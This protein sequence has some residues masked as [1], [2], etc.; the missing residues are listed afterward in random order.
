MT[1]SEQNPNQPTLRRPEIE[2]AWRRATMSGLDP[3]ME[4]RE[5]AISDVE[6]RSTLSIAAGPV[7]DKMVDELADTRFSILLADRTS[8]IVDRRVTSSAIGRAL[9]R[10]LAVPGFQYLEEV[11]GT[12]SLATAFELRRPIAVTGEEHFLEALRCFCCYGV[13]IIHPVTHRLEGVI[14][15]SGPV[16]DATT[17]L[18]PF[19]M[20]AAR[21]IEERLLEGS[22]VAEKQLLAE[23]QAHANQ[24]R[25]AVVA[26][27]ENLVLTNTAAVDLVKGSDHVAL[28]AIA[29]DLPGT[30]PVE[31]S[32]TLSSGTEVSVRARAVSGSHGG[33][34]FEI[35]QEDI[36]RTRRT[37]GPSTAPVISTQDNAPP[38]N[39]LS[40][41]ILI[42][43]EP[44]T[45]RTTTART[46]AGA[47]CTVSDAADAIEDERQWFLDVR[48]ALREDGTPVVIDN[49]HALSPWLA[50]QLT[51]PVRVSRNQVV[52]TSAPLT[53]LGTAHRALASLALTRHELQPLRSYP[54]KL[55]S[56]AKSV[57]AEIL[58]DSAVELA[59][60]ALQLLA[61]QPWPGNI[62]ELRAVLQYAARGRERGMIIESDLPETVRMNTQS[63]RTLTL[64][65][66]AE[67]DAI[68]AALR[69]SHGNRA[70]AAAELGIGRTTL[71]DRLRRYGI[72]DA[73]PRTSVRNRNSSTVRDRRM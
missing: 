25:H 54:H 50:D 53:E 59:P 11:S 30:A 24:R 56:V 73:E 70:A 18:G 29:A 23:F 40:R 62:R 38:R 31:R 72:T 22:R 1:T 4:V 48:S 58:P 68:V 14:D 20:R 13:P 52:L 47:D 61:A 69:A 8:R 33:A 10:V 12:N 19:L 71:Y 16:A 64:M 7:L 15:V 17:L 45:G 3:G 42:T 55:A 21:D 37:A 65:E 66:T 49:L 26:L 57:L 43:G 41:T 51:A 63:T 9:D 6:T 2:L 35:T 5:T 67:R 32:L 36:P 27:G 60:S 44:G 34:L 39:G 46:M 28:R